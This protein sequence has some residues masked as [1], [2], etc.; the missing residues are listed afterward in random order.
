MKFG[1]LI[2]HN[3]IFFFKNHAQ[4]DSGTLATKH[5]LFFKKALYRVKTRGLQPIF[6]IFQ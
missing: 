4:N 3:K 5:F 6:K 1:P 2:E